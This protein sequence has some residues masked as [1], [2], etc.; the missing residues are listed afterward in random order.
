M[1]VAAR[2]PVTAEHTN[3]VHL[4]GRLSAEPQARELPSGDQVVTFRL[5]VSRDGSGR[6]VSGGRSPTVDTIDCAAW[7]KGVQRSLRACQAGD[8]LEVRGR[9]APTVLAGTARAVE[10]QRGR[11]HHAATRGEGGWPGLTAASARPVR[12]R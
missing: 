3:E 5:V 6:V 10:P 1:A 11:G 8:L 4:V 7:T 12:P 2:D 9:A